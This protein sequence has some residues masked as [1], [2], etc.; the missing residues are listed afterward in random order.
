MNTNPYRKFI[1]SG[2]FLLCILVIGTLGY[3]LLGR[4][5]DSII[6]ALYMTVITVTTI[7]FTE[8][9]DLTNNPAGRIFTM[10]IAISGIGVVAYAATNFTVLLVEGQL[11]DSFKRRHMENIIKKSKGHY[12]VC[13][14]GTTGLHIIGELIS[15]KR[16]VIIIDTDKSKLDRLMA[17]YKNA[18]AIEGNPTENE[19]L[20]KAGII[21]ASGLFAV[22]GDDNQNLVIGLTA[23]QINPQM[24]VV[25]EC[26]EISNGDKMKKAGVDSVVSPSYIGGLRMASEMIRPT[27]VSFLD[28]MLRDRDKNLRVEEI[29]VPENFAEKKLGETGLKVLSHS[30]LLAIKTKGDWVYNPPDDDMV[31][32]GDILVFMTTPEGRFEV[33]EKI[34]RG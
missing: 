19:V 34:Q 12:I 8:V 1:W 7:G 27:V 28:V 18:A 26:H 13:G 32:A 20:M 2:L 4:G 24:R 6:D 25:A 17:I 30:L 29:P 5:Q 9:I 14:T 22:S 11:T 33:E 10:F 21:Q 23:K 3:R 31:R 15:T 16:G